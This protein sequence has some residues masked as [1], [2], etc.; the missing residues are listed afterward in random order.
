[1]LLA[2]CSSLSGTGGKG[3]ITSDGTVTEIE[4]ADRGAPIELADSDLE[5]EPVSLTELRGK[6]VVVNVWWSACPPCI[7]EQ[8]DLNEVAGE[9]EGRAS[10]VGINIRD[11]S[12]E[13]AQAYVRGQDVPYPSIYSP[14]GRA[15]LSFANDL[16]PRDIPSTVVLDR[17]GRIAAVVRGAIPSR[18]T[19]VSVVEKV[20]REG[21]DE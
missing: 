12:V 14:D 18:Q 19:L 9:L 11:A 13:A 21:P 1:V 2:G 17:E 10:F 3:Y 15:L 7:V 6:P 16:G 20:L 4:P 8:P 5:G